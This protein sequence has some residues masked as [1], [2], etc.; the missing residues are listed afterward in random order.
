M[1]QSRSLITS[2]NYNNG[3]KQCRRRKRNAKSIITAKS[4]FSEPNIALR[5]IVSGKQEENQS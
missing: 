4:V 2:K 5:F 1:C 3:E